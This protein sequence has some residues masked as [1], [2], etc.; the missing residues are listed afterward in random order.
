VFIDA[1]VVAR[2][3]DHGGGG[4][5]SGSILRFWGVDVL[6]DRKGIEDKLLKGYSYQKC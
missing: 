6:Q 1:L 2:E 5:C 4:N 3:V